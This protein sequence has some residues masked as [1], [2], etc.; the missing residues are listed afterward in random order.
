MARRR[1]APVVIIRKDKR[2]KHKFLHTAL[3]AAT[4][5]MS[6]IVTAAAVTSNAGYNARTRKLQQEAEQAST[7]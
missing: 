4:G 2:I 1:G 7:D 6:G 5:G 3:F